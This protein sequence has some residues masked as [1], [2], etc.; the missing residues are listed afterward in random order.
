MA[1][2]ICTK[3]LL[4]LPNSKKFFNNNSRPLKDGTRK[5][6][7]RN[8]CKKCERKRINEWASSVTK[9]SKR[10]RIK[11]LVDAAKGRAKKNGI[12]FDI[13]VD[14]LKPFPEV[15]EIFNTELS[16]TNSRVDD[17]RNSP[18]LDRVIP[19]LGYIK[20]NVRIISFKA[21]ELKSYNTPDTLIAI[22]KYLNVNTKKDA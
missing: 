15:C 18:S 13:H 12:P 11:T 22:L 2:K 3:C 20:G 14:D 5:Y 17:R 4:S 16:Y 6:F 1:N 21:N 8:V 9:T 10:A 7:L 19:E